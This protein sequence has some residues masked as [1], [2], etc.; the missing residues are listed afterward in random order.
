MPVLKFIGQGSC[1]EAAAGD[2]APQSQ[3]HLRV[4]ACDGLATLDLR[5]AERPMKRQRLV[6]FLM[7][8]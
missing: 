6:P 7:E 4:V 5:V 3:S 8:C 1:C 2:V